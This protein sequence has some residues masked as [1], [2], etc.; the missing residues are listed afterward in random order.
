[1]SFIKNGESLR[2]MEILAALP[3]HQAVDEF[4]IMI[5]AAYEPCGSEYKDW[6]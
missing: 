6:E 2:F 1:M 3:G 5:P 4:W